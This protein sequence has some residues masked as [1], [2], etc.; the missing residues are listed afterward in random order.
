MSER[1]SSL[2]LAVSAALALTACDAPPA[3]PTAATTATEAPATPARAAPLTASGPPV[4]LTLAEDTQTD[5]GLQWAASVVK[6]DDL[7]GVSAKLFGVAG[8]DPA[9]NGLNT[10]IAFYQNPADGWAIYQIGDFLD[11]TV[12]SNADGRVDLEVQESTMDE[13]KG[14]IG[15]GR[16][17]I[18]IRWTMDADGA[19]PTEVTVTPAQ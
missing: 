13:A 1:S 14:E 4:A 18:I 5:N 9:M 10:Y 3:G 12:L 7:P 6:S 8:G 15:D 11:Y 16:R 2:S 17:K 19:A